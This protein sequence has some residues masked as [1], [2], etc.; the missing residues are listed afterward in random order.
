MSKYRYTD[1]QVLCVKEKLA[2]ARRRVTLAPG[3]TKRIAQEEG[4]S[5]PTVR[6]ILNGYR[7][8]DDDAPSSASA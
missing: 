1:E 5:H 6:A 7:H 4:M 3:E 2:K 8:V